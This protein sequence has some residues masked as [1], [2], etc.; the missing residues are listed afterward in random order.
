M[1]TLCFKVWQS[2]GK[3]RMTTKALTKA[4]VVIRG[5]IR[6][7]PNDVRVTDVKETFEF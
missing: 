1:N 3:P 4:F 2:F 6:G 7:L 5:V